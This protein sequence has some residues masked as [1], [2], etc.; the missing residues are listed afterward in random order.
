M[1]ENQNA[2]FTKSIPNQEKANELIGRLFDL[3]Q[4]EAVFNQPVTSGDYT[5]ITASEL[6]AIMGT[7]YGG[8]RSGEE[9]QEA[10]DDGVT[11]GGGGGG[12]G[13][14]GTRPVAYIQIGPNGVHMEPIV[15]ATKIALAF[16]TMFGAMLSIWSKMRRVEKQLN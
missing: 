15:D 10:S 2:F 3:A 4:P 7:G 5:V 16:F 14:V 6:T 13:A 12:G 8:G 9:S 11:F 1:S